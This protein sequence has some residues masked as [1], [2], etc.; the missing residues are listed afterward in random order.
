MSSVFKVNANSASSVLG[1]RLRQ[2][3]GV[4][5]T[6]TSGAERRAAHQGMAWKWERSESSG[7]ADILKNWYV[8]RKKDF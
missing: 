5:R 6:V 3:D 7:K 2:L 8:Q 4:G 1:L